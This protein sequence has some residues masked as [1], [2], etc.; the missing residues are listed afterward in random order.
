[1]R[2]RGALAA[3]LSL[4][5]LPAALSGSRAWAEIGATGTRLSVG[6]G[7]PRFYMT[8]G[9]LDDVELYAPIIPELARVQV[10]F[11]RR[12][13]D[14]LVF[15]KGKPIAEWPVVRSRQALPETGEHPCILVLGGSVFV[16][17][18]KLAELCSLK[19]SWDRTTNVASLVPGPERPTGPIVK[20]VTPGVPQAGRSLTGVVLEAKGKGVEIRVQANPPVTPVLKIVRSPKPLRLVLDFPGSRWA[21][22]VQAPDA[23]G[24]VQA[25]RIGHPEPDTARLVLEVPSLAY[26]ITRLSVTQSEVSAAVGDVAGPTVAMVLQPPTIAKPPTRPLP[27]RRGARMSAPRLASA[28][29]GKTICLDAGHGGHDPGALGQGSRE[30]DLCL[31]MVLQLKEAL[32]AYGATVVLTRDSD[33]YVSLQDRCAIANSRAS[34]LFISIHCNSTP[35][36]NSASGSETY[37]NTPQSL[38]LA[39]ILHDRVTSTVGGRDGGIR[40]RRFYVVRNTAMPSVLLEIGYINNTGDEE[41]LSSSQFHSDLAT[42]LAQGVVEFFNMAVL[43]PRG[44][45]KPLDR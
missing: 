6:N 25:V 20:P 19:L 14:Y 18:Q 39:Q 38:P 16:P 7:A 17:V 4:V 8:Y 37:W 9:Y 45:L 2:I 44:D 27:D 29:L 30:K 5:A 11:E 36:P 40:N 34:D 10:T 15:H 3:L 31:K 43:D 23:A 28:L 32:E 41:L 33:T 21:D 26:R 24:P 22:G 35:R 42:S 1:M 13:E 12:G